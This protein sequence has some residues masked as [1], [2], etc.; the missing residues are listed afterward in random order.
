MII[1]LHE[2]RIAPAESSGIAPFARGLVK[3]IAPLNVTEILFGV[4]SIAGRANETPELSARHLSTPDPERLHTHQVDRLFIRRAVTRCVA[5]TE[6]T[7]ANHGHFTGRLSYF[8]GG[9]MRGWR[10]RRIDDPQ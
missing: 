1:A 10:G 7:A 3:L 8:G 2:A 9:H 4:G 5:H 6:F